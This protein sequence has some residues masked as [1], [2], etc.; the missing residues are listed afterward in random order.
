VALELSAS[1]GV[2]E[3]VDCAVAVPLKRRAAASAR[4]GLVNDVMLFSRTHTSSAVVVRFN[5]YS[6]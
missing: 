1:E 2:A 6:G 4:L 3:A 5:N